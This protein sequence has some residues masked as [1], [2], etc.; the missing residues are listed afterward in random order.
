M[1]LWTT[2]PAVRKNSGLLKKLNDRA[3]FCCIDRR[4]PWGRDWLALLE[5]HLNVRQ[6]GKT[7]SDS[8]EVGMALVGVGGPTLSLAAKMLK[9]L[10]NLKM[11]SHFS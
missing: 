3:Q 7:S 11:F 2:R 4:K 8:E 1:D 9:H 10:Q 5:M 6:K